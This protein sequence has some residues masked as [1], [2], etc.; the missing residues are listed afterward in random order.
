MKK[1]LTKCVVQRLMCDTGMFRVPL[2]GF[3]AGYL[4]QDRGRAKNICGH[5]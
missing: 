3:K 4:K 2:T 1:W 5:A